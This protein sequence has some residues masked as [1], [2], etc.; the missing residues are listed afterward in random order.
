[1]NSWHHEFGWECEKLLDFCTRDREEITSDFFLERPGFARKHAS[2]WIEDF[3][4]FHGVLV[5]DRALPLGQLGLCDMNNGW[6]FLST[7]M[8]KHAD[9]EKAAKALRVSTLAHELGHLRLHLEED[10]PNVLVSYFGE[11][12]LSHPRAYQREMEA[13][14]YAGAFL[15]PVESLVGQKATAH[16]WEHREIRLAMKSPFI[17]KQIY[18]AAGQFGVTPTLM[19]KRLIDLGWMRQISPRKGQKSAVLELLFD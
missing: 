17:W 5:D 9:S 1:M 8:R 2:V 19:K 13:D 15:L 11:N 6:I 10:V 18:E 12:R 16:L 4:D 3:L 14:L 7:A